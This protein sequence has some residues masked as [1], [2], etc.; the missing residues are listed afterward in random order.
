[1]KW[2]EVK[3]ITSSEYEDI[4]TN[5]LYEAGANGL[6]IEDPD[7]ILDLKKRETDWDFIESS[8]LDYDKEKIVIKAYFPCTEDFITILESLRKKIEKTPKLLGERPYGKLKTK[9]LD[10]VDY[11][12]NWKQYF[13]TFKIGEKIV[14]KPTWE[15]YEEKENDLIIEI[16]PGMAFGTGGHE[17]TSM[18]ISAL[19]KYLKDHMKVFDIG[20]GSGILSIV[21]AK[22]GAKQVTAIDLD[23]MSI[24]ASKENV[25][26]NKVEDIVKV[27]KGDLLSTIEGKADLVVANIVAEVIVEMVKDLGKYIKENGIFIGSGIIEEKI[28]MV[29]EVLIDNNFH[30]LEI[31]GMN[32]WSL[33]VAR[34]G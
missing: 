23:E 7:D 6:A 12:E 29:E 5:I 8:L 34:R 24:K 27:E 31:E 2:T 1:M 32:D 10:D 9:E 33:I 21:S 25:S 4:I 26:L 28:P 13:K 19:E 18:C 30:I 15:D 16:D 11:S 14:I 17:T 20:C 22:L 3:V